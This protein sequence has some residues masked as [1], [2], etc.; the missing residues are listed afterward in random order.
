VAGDLH[1][2]EA[3]ANNFI[4]VEHISCKE[5]SNHKLYFGKACKR[6]NWS[7]WRMIWSE[8]AGILAHV[9]EVGSDQGF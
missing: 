1:E 4:R 3:R 2:E 7:G 6:G 5:K 8:R 9:K